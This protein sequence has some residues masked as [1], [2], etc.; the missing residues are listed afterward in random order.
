MTP[1]V[2]RA[3]ERL[4][5]DAMALRLGIAVGD[6]RTLEGAET[7]LWE[8]RTLAQYVRTLGYSL[9]LTLTREGDGRRLELDQ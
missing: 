2:L 9:R 7:G 8:V 4:S 3:R 1:R 5:L 6:L